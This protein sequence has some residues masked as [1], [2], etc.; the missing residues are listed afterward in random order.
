[1]AQELIKDPARIVSQV[2]YEYG[3]N[4]GTLASRDRT[5]HVSGAR[6][7]AIQRLRKDTQ[8]SFTEIGKMLRRD[9]TSVMALAKVGK[10][11][12][13]ARGKTRDKPV[14]KKVTARGKARG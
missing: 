3:L 5:P 12:G 14:N 11:V 10:T 1:M 8:M 6:R 9:H 2:E 13:T 7:V 4:P